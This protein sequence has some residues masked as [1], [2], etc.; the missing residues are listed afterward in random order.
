MTR[1]DNAPPAPGLISVSLAGALLC[2]IPQILAA[3]LV[4]DA[5][6]PPV[7]MAP[8]LGLAVAL[9]IVWGNRALPGILGGLV[10]GALLARD[11]VEFPIS[12]VQSG[13]WAFSATI[14]AALAGHGIRLG[15]RA[16][17]SSL[18]ATRDFLI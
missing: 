10:L 9:S 11:L 15:G 4:G 14:G 3:L 2:G 5:W 12:L 17:L 8:A 7:G 18:A 1:P 6:P 16:P 13:A